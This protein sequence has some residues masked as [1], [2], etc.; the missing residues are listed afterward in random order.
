[1][2]LELGL[3]FNVYVVYLLLR[4]Y[5]KPSEISLANSGTIP[6]NGENNLT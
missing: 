2:I 3:L 5:S 4:S 6:L 1:M